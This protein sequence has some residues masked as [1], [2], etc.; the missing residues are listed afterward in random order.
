MIEEREE[1]TG[2]QSKF[3]FLSDSPLT[4]ETKQNDRFGH[5][6]IAENLK[7]IVSTCPLPFTIGLFGRWGTGKTSILNILKGQLT[8]EKNIPVVI[9]D[10]WKH[11]GDAL[12][13]TFLR[14]IV[15][16]LKGQGLC[17]DFKLTERVDASIGIEKKSQKL[18]IFT[19]AATYIL[20]GLIIS[21][22]VIFYYLFDAATFKSYFSLVT[23]SSL[24]GALLIFLIQR[25]VVTEDVTRTSARFEDPHEFEKEFLRIINAITKSKSRRL[26]IA[27]DNLDRCTRDNAVKLLKTIKTFLAKDTGTDANNRCVFLIPCDDEAIKSH[28]ESVYLNSKR[29]FGQDELTSSVVFE[30]GFDSDEFLR[31]FF[32]T[33]LILPN[34]IDTELQEYTRELLKES[35]VPEFD[36]PDVAHVIFMAFRENPR[37]IKQFINILISHFLMAQNRE[38][39]DSPLIIPLGTI[40]ENVP[41][42]AKFLLVRQI[43]PNPYISIVQKSLPPEEWNEIS[44][45]EF[46]NF[47]IATS[48]FTV[49][50]I[51][52]FIFLKHSREQLQIPGLREIE[53]K[54]CNPYLKSNRKKSNIFIR[55]FLT[56]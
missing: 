46:K 3:K 43:F 54:S 17:D 52:P 6:G 25:M 29:I 39:S 27:I 24:V 49:P 2:T 1:Q 10:V 20:I 37:Q 23:G 51:R 15:S 42:L 26:L 13:R 7:Q 28:L 38:I 19:C 56:K 21:L 44:D 5:L 18:N 41:F 12:R 32:N 14:E 16:Q 55:A 34:F 47:H 36:N 53:R 33:F 35:H 40:T 31:K 48:M 45:T 4:A 11:E 22:G 8:K 30:K 50:D 9:F